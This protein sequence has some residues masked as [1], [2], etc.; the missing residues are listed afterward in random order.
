MRSP[1]S[2]SHSETINSSKV[3]TFKGEIFFN[4]GPDINFICFVNW[5]EFKFFYVYF[6]M[7]L[8]FYETLKYSRMIDTLRF[9]GFFLKE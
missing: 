3:N 6:C 5:T 9:L 4:I 8:G 7:F 2:L 1:F